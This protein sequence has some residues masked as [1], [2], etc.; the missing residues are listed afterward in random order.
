MTYKV[1]PTDRAAV[2][3]GQSVAA[4]VDGRLSIP[5]DEKLEVAA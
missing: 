5:K 2:E 4:L 1:F 3:S